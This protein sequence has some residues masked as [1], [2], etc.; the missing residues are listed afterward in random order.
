M[1]GVK[2]EIKAR[3][4]VEDV[5]G[6]YLELKRAGRNLKALS[7]WTSERTPSFMV[8][9]EKGIWHD[10]S[11]NKG[12]DIFTFIMEV[13]GINFKEAL[14][15]L[16]RQAGVELEKYG[17]DKELSRRKARAREALE[18]TT[19]FYQ[20]ALSKSRKMADYVFYK[21]NM[22]RATAEEFRIG[23]SPEGGK[24]LADFLTA[25]G[26]TK[27]EMEDAGL[28]NRFGG[29]LFKGRMMV[30]LMDSVGMVVGFTGRI[31]DDKDKNSPKY[32]NTPETLLYNK[33]RH[34]FGFSQAK[35][36]IRKSGFVVVVEGNMDVISSH[37]AGVKE[38]V[39]TA[40]TA[41]TEAHLK[42][43]SRLT[44]DVRLAYD[45]DAAGVAA[46]ERA[47]SIASEL[48]IDLS[49]V[50]DYEGAKDPDELIQRGVEL[51]RKAIDKR[52]P[53]IDWLLGKYEEKLDLETGAGKREY[54]TVAMKLI[55]GLSDSVEREHYEAK[56][57]EAL[58]VSV[59]AL[60]EKK[61]EGG[62]K[63]L[64][65]I[66]TSG[67][68]VG[69]VEADVIDR[70]CAILLYGGASIP[71]GLDISLPKD[72][73]RRQELKLMFEHWYA[74]MGQ[75]D[76]EKELTE[77]TKRLENE[78]TKRDLAD[79]RQK[80][81]ETIEAGDDEEAKRLNKEIKKLEQQK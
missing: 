3:L 78:K 72:D 68:T 59:V 52:E 51:W 10:F 66:T 19:K 60:R 39:A 57:A 55:R 13:E 4:A 20:F 63:R 45:G 38:A 80:F 27:R 37:Q 31:L 40:G 11:S 35:E 65:K 12:G 17:E 69:A 54:S 30:S 5:V 71:E 81:A 25:R 75:S 48:G 33:G 47:I 24:K 23:F 18:I 46:A 53:A 62:V 61:V 70:A 2:E 79:L 26:F 28:L 6:Q 43:L 49:I 56:V 77:L 42:A 64:K 58:G 16:A 22:N 73:T 15:K 7:P 1:D 50:S 76:L 29:D 74:A 32:L 14:E 36:A 21:R 41:M 9:P 44:S 67:T 8:S 34:I